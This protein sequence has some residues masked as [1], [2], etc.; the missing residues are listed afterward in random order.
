MVVT[1]INILSSEKV[2]AL[3]SLSRSLEDSFA[4]LSFDFDDSNS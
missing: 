1:D 3:G 4:V 2:E